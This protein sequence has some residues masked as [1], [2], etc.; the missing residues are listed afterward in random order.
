[1]EPG[2]ARGAP[3]RRPASPRIR[4]SALTVQVVDAAGRPVPNAKVELQQTRHAF[5]FG[6][7]IDGDT[8]LW[9]ED[10]LPEAEGAS[11][12]DAIIKNFNMVTIG[13]SWKWVALG[14]ETEILPVRV[15]QWC[16]DHR[17]T[18]RGHNMVWPSWRHIPDSIKAILKDR[19]DEL[20]AAVHAPRRGGRRG[21][22]ALRVHVGCDQ[23]NLR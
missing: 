12:Q 20:R 19:P 14:E 3:K 8:D 21:C 7:A 17:L 11:Y 23:R 4:Q 6:T 1:M 10:S 16:K 15:S 13:N 18:L 2:R 22:R 9:R 5:G